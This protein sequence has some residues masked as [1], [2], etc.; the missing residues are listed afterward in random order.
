[1]TYLWQI[2]PESTDK[3]SGGDAEI[4]PKP[5]PGIFSKSSKK[6]N[7]VTFTLPAKPGQYRLFLYIF[8]GQKN[9]ATG[10]IPFMI[11]TDL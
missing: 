2:V 3:K 4:A 11:A 6:Q 10:N 1:L 8:D 7:Q 5:L 9:V